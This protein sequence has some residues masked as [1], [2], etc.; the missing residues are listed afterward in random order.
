MSN[1]APLWP[2]SLRA[3]QPLGVLEGDMWQVPPG[4][5]LIENEL[6]GWTLMMLEDSRRLLGHAFSKGVK[7]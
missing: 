4:L 7:R 6:G 5:S 1:Q 2:G 3:S